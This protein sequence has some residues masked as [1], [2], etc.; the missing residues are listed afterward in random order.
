MGRCSGTGAALATAPGEMGD[1]AGELGGLR[2]RILLIDIERR[3]GSVPIFDQRVRGG[4][5]PVHQWTRLPELLCFAAKWHGERRVEFHAAWDD[6]G[7]MLLRAWELYDEADIVVTYN[8]VR[9]DNPHL[10]GAWLEAGYP[11]PS[12]WRDVDLFRVAHQFGYESRSLAHLCQRLGLPGKAGRYSAADA[13]ACMA[14]DETAQ[15]RMKR[16]NLGDVG[17]RS[18]EGVYDRLLPW[19]T[20]HPH[21][22]LWTGEERSCNRCGSTNL[23]PDGWHRTAVTSYARYRCQDCGGHVRTTIVKSRT[24]TRPAG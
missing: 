4:F 24:T 12:P 21:I 19:I 8:G 15:R 10:K 5:I 23:K 16:Y 13:E 3:A 6:A 22:G 18:L 17:Q 14:G 7:A 1:L 20:G 11:P 9:F 2:P